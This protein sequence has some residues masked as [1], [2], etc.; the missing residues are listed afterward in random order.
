M[1]RQVKNRQIP[2]LSEHFRSLLKVH[3]STVVRVD[4]TQV[5]KFRALVEVGHPRSG[6]LDQSLRQAVDATRR[7]QRLAKRVEA[8][9]KRVISEDAK[10][11]VLKF[12]FVELVGF[13]PRAVD[14]CL[15]HGLLQVGKCAL[16]GERVGS[17]ERL[18]EQ[19]LGVAVAVA[20]LPGVGVLLSPG[21]ALLAPGARKSV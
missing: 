19:I 9:T 17:D 4:K 1:L 16:P 7:N 21:A 14:F 5:P 20:A 3:R 6:Q 8:A 2:G 12:F 15:A 10:D 18:I 11:K 13:V